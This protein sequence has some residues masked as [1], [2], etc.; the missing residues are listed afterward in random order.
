MKIYFETDNFVLVLKARELFSKITVRNKEINKIIN[1]K[2][3]R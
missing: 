3:N 1:E 2:K